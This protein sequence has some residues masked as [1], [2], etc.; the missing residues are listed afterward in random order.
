MSTNFLKYLL[1]G[2]VL[3]GCSTTAVK[4]VEVPIPVKCNPPQIEKPAFQYPS[5]VLPGESVF[6]MT[7]CVLSDIQLHLGYEQQLEAALVGC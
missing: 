4:T 6:N 1:L 3:S 5:C 7:R 2:V